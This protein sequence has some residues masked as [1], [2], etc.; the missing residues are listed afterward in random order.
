MLQL[1]KKT[2]QNPFDVRIFKPQTNILWRR[3]L[4]KRCVIK[5]VLWPKPSRG[6]ISIGLR[7]GRASLRDGGKKP[8]LRPRS[9]KPYK[10]ALRL[11]YACSWGD[12][13]GKILQLKHHLLSQDIWS[14]HLKFEAF[15]QTLKTCKLYLFFKLNRNS[16]LTGLSLWR[17]LAGRDKGMMWADVS[18][19]D[20]RTCTHT[21]SLDCSNTKFLF[22]FEMR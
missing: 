3:Y 12:H 6:N 9:L 10:G 22:N 18:I 19:N 2:F 1:G 13:A 5:G 16:W 17:E 21:C 11:S 8:L 15:M 14:V 7:G 20:I 4:I